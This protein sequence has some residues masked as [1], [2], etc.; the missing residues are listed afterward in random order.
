MAPR[1]TRATK[2]V[3]PAQRRVSSKSKG[4]TVSKAKAPAKVTKA[5]PKSSKTASPEISLCFREAVVKYKA[6]EITQ[7]EYLQAIVAHC[8]GSHHGE[9]QQCNGDS[10]ANR[11][12]DRS[13]RKF[14]SDLTEADDLFAYTMMKWIHGD[15]CQ[16]RKQVEGKLSSI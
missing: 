12:R 4:V 9:N 7:D 5:R 10:T 8:T 11:A 2:S 13:T 16:R 3:R 1:K 15:V 14:A 6:N